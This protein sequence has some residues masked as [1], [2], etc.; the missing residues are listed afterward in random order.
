MQRPWGAR[1]KP[2]LGPSCFLTVDGECPGAG[3]EPQGGGWQHPEVLLGWLWEKAPRA[4]LLLTTD[5]AVGHSI[6]GG[7]REAYG[8]LECERGTGILPYRIRTSGG[9]RVKDP[10]GA[11]K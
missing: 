6:Q 7:N 11:S 5:K 1:W 9:L 4:Q 3:W 2:Q 8:A 10:D